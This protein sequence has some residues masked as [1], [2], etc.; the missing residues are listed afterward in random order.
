MLVMAG[1]GFKLAL[2]PFH[3]W[4]PDVYESA[5]TSLTAFMATGVKAMIILFTIRLVTNGLLPAGHLWGTVLAFMAAASLIAG[6]TMGLVQSSLKRM[7]AYSSIAHSGYMAIAACAVAGAGYELPVQA[8]LYY[9]VTYSIISLGAFA[10]IMWLETDEIDNLQLDDIAGLSKTHPLASFALAVF[11]IALAG[12]PPTVGFMSKF[13][14]FN[15][16]ISANLMGLVIIGVLGSTISL[17]YYLR[18]IV[19]MYM[20]EQLPNAPQLGG[21]RGGIFGFIA[22]AS[23]V[24]VVLTGALLV[25]PSFDLFAVKGQ[26]STAFQPMSDTEVV[27]D[28]H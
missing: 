22:A 2:V 12:L 18:T 19:K 6:N 11:M 4:A 25:G 8:L 5:P 21:G 20:T 26:K 23:L 24:F 17:Y 9:V 27:S 14:I 1:I 15:A 3:M 28:S 16:A 7:L 13:F 10:V